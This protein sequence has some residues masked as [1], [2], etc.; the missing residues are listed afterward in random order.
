MSIAFCHFWIIR[1]SFPVWNGR[2]CNIVL[3]TKPV[4][5]GRDSIISGRF[6]VDFSMIY[7]ELWRCIFWRSF[8]FT[9]STPWSIPRRSTAS[10]AFWPK[11]HPRPKLIYSR[12]MHAWSFFILI[13]SIFTS[14]P[15]SCADHY[16]VS[17]IVSFFSRR[18]FLISFRDSCWMFMHSFVWLNFMLIWQF[19]LLSNANFM[20]ISILEC[21]NNQFVNDFLISWHSSSLSNFSIKPESILFISFFNL[22]KSSKV[23]IKASIIRRFILIP[24]N[25]SIWKHSENII[26]HFIEGEHILIF[27]M[28]RVIVV[29]M[30]LVTS[31]NVDFK[32]SR[33]PLRI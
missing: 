15:V 30:T 5:V 7:T 18:L 32:S 6:R 19:F 31:G 33:V 11:S 24:N 2:M 8:V 21:E 17:N 10:P 14:T 23:N 4:R 25:L 27:R 3:T 16:S 29:K 22:S 9:F 28:S 13:F 1:L 12:M 26:A 20:R